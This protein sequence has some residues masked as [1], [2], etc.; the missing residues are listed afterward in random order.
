M[1]CKIVEN[2]LSQDDYEKAYNAIQLL[3]NSDKDHTFN[4]HLETMKTVFK[5]EVLVNDIKT[6]MKMLGGE[7]GKNQVRSLT[8]W[9][10]ELY[11]L[12]EFDGFGGYCPLHVM[13]RGGYLHPH[14]DHSSIRNGEFIH[15][16]NC[17]LYMNKDWEEKW[18]GATCFYKVNSQN[19]FNNKVQ[20]KQSCLPGP[21]RALAFVHDSFAFH[22]VSYVKCPNYIDRYTY[23]MDY[24]IPRSKLTE[25]KEAYLNK[26][27]IE[28]KH[29]YHET[30][31]LPFKLDRS[32]KFLLFSLINREAIPYVRR[33]IRY[34]ISLN[35]EKYFV[36][37]F[38]ITKLLPFFNNLIS[39]IDFIGTNTLKPLLKP[40]YLSIKKR[41]NQHQI[42]S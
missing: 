26:N 37:P 40:I 17:I 39:I 20:V 23:Y 18:G 12:L 41:R 15:I 34:L 28:F 7:E 4:T 13:H 42:N 33:Y 8:G 9:N 27:N 35:K 10:G 22:G 16:G 25:F 24:Y 32:G 2:F 3:K 14:L 11:S 36:K 31:H 6:P 5:S 21:N 30:I 29:S 38:T 19:F 1:P